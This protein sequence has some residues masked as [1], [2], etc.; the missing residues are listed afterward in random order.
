MCLDD[1]LS[2]LLF[3][4]ENSEICSRFLS[5]WYIFPDAYRDQIKIDVI[6]F[7][8]KKWEKKLLQMCFLV[9]NFFSFISYMVKDD[10]SLNVLS[11]DV[12]HRTI[13]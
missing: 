4:F 6:C 13:N 7:L 5:C 12:K 1:L 11:N 3:E 10:P 2:Y 9:S 8:S